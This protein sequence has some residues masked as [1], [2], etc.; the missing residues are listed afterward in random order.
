MSLSSGYENLGLGAAITQPF[1]SL[2][3]GNLSFDALE[4]AYQ[5]DLRNP[6]KAVLTYLAH[7]QN[8]KTRRCDPSVPRIA[9]DCGLSVRTVQNCLA[10]LERSGAIKRNPR[11]DQT[12]RYSFPQLVHV[13]HPTGAR[14]APGVVHVVHP[15]LEVRTRSEPKPRRQTR[16]ARDRFDEEMEQRRKLTAR[17]LREARDGDLR[18]ELMVGSGPELIRSAR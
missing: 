1:P 18:K 15:E 2:R 12:T 16:A 3:E 11:P 13:V 4:W 7:R 9:K 14:P 6:S 8:H 5:Q 10:D 17:L